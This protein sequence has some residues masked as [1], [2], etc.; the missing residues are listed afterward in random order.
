[1]EVQYTDA[2]ADG[3]VAAIC[4]QESRIWVFD[5]DGQLWYLMEHGQ[6]VEPRNDGSHR[7][8]AWRCQLCSICTI[9]AHGSATHSGAVFLILRLFNND[10]DSNDR[11]LKP[12]D[13]LGQELLDLGILRQQL[14][15]RRI[16]DAFQEDMHVKVVFLGFSEDVSHEWDHLT[17][18]ALDQQLN[19]GPLRVKML[20]VG[21]CHLERRIFRNGKRW[22]TG[23]LLANLLAVQL[24]YLLLLI[25]ECTGA[26]ADDSAWH[27]ADIR[28]VQTNIWVWHVIDAI[29]VF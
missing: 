18:F 21:F 24:G 3:E 8:N 13:T 6:L 12:F 27:P 25:V 20:L 15:L 9:V 23:R 16:L 17:V 11:L 7:K 22:G 1:M 4:Q 2:L 26:S 10:V 5:K 19:I 29:H 14:R 28:Q